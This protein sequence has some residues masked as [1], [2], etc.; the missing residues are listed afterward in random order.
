MQ[1]KRNKKVAPSA[2]TG[3]IEVVLLKLI[4]TGYFIAV[5]LIKSN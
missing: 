1:L 4:L 5:T 2:R 3:I